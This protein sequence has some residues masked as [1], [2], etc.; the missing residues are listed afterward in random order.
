M[1]IGI[2]L[3]AIMVAMLT[4]LTPESPYFHEAIIMVFLGF[5]LGLVMPVMNL[6]VQSEFKQSDLGA[7][8]SSVQLFRGL[9]STVGIALFGALLTSGITAN[10]TNIQDDAYIQSLSASQA[11]EQIG[12]LND[13]NTLLS[14]NTPGVKDKITDGF[15]E[16][17][18]Q[19]PTPA[20]DEAVKEFSKS[21]NEYSSKIVHAFSHS[22]RDIFLTSAVLMAIAAVLVFAIKERELA[23]ASPNATPGEV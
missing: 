10:L 9:G 19:L 16:S 4:T 22:L 15:K 3:A 12:D 13:S 17:T 8:T 2:V 7:A 23:A 11:A 1:Q 21:Q 14:L 18:A 6:V 20:R 5:G